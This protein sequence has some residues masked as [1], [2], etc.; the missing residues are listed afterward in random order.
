MC[1]ASGLQFTPTQERVK[2]MQHF[3]L[4]TKKKNIL[5]I[6]ILE[7]MFIYDIEK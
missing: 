7:K 3:D 2:A 5:Q 1:V 4:K 6:I